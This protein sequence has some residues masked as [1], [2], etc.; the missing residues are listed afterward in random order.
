MLVPCFKVF[1]YE[2]SQNLKKKWFEKI[3]KIE[4]FWI[5]DYSEFNFKLFFER[6][7]AIDFHKVYY[8]LRLFAV[9]C[10]SLPFYISNFTYEI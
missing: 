8:S 4:I 10:F 2:T 6:E 9:E 1:N 3:K 7:I 5:F